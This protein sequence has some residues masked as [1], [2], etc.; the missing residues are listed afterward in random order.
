MAAHQELACKAL[1]ELVSDY[2]EGVLSPD[3][4]VAF[5]EHLEVCTGCRL[6][7]G[8]MRVTVRSLQRLPAQALSPEART[9]LL[10]QFR[11][12]AAQRA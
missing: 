2:L 8:Q 4:R 7:L 9:S 5:E 6:Y 11:V 1:V 10:Q 12:W 3:V